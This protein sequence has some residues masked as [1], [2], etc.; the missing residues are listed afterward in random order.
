M[1]VPSVLDYAA[2][3]VR[4]FDGSDGYYQQCR[5]AIRSLEKMAGRTLLV[6][7]LSETLVNDWLAHS[8]ECMSSQTR[9]SRRNIL[10]RLWKHAATNP[11]L[12]A[13][14][15]MP[16]RD[17][18]GRVKRQRPV[19]EAWP[20][21]D[22]RRLFLVADHLRGTF[23][24]GMSKRLFWRA[25]I[26]TAWSTGWRRCDIVLLNLSDIGTSGRLIVVQ[27]KTFRHVVSQLLPEAMAAI[28]ELCLHHGKPQVFPQWCS[29]PTWRKS[30]KRLVKR[31]GLRRAIGRLRSSAGTAV[32][33][34]QPGAGPTFLGNS[35]AVFYAHYH[36]RRIAE[37]LPTPPPLTG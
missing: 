8:K 22:V 5:W 37:K 21:D 24:N 25:Y 19:P 6:T 31:A 23:V 3:Y 11:A 1:A 28:N 32:E 26:L 16:N 27:Q 14:P 13:K 4:L 7:D 33:A 35:A 18:I 36:D 20:I 10:L 29:I 12:A 15:P 9:L 2:F 30:A 34:V 17:F